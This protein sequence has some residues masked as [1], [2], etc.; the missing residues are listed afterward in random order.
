MDKVFVL[1]Y[2]TY[3]LNPIDPSLIYPYALLQNFIWNEFTWERKEAF[4]KIQIFVILRQF[5]YKSIADRIIY[6]YTLKLIRIV[7]SFFSSII[8]F[9]GK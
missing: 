3:S 4:V 9:A 1:C 7:I 2:L 8:S 5:T 6:S